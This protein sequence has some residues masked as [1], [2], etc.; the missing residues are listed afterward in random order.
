MEFVSKG[1][2]KFFGDYRPG[3]IIKELKKLKQQDKLQ[4]EAP[5]TTLRSQVADLKVEPA[6]KNEEI[7]QLWVQMESL[8]RIREVVETLGD[9][10]NKAHL[11]DNDIKIEGQ[12]LAAKIIS[13]LVNFMWKME[14]ALVD[15]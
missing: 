6:M 14:A 4:L 13:I 1:A 2:S 8:E 7:Y 3:N 10:L 12:L 15:I 5:N 11:F 9:V